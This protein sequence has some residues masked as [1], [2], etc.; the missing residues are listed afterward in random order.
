M[1]LCSPV[2][3]FTFFLP[4]WIN[5]LQKVRAY[6]TCLWEIQQNSSKV[7]PEENSKESPEH[8]EFHMEWSD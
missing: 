6:N 7:Q 3:I 4:S 8:M 2:V 5:K 1:P